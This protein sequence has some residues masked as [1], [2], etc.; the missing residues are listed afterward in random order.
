MNK[1]SDPL[2]IDFPKD[3]IECWERYPKYRWVYE[4]SRLLDSQ[5]IKWSPYEVGSLPDR[6]LNIE[7]KSIKPLIRQS[8]LIYIKKPSGNHMFTELYV[9]KGEIKFLRHIDPDTDKE[10]DS[11]IGEIELRINAFM[12]LYFQKFT[13]VMTI[14]TYGHEI[15]RVR[16]RPY[17]DISLETNQEIIKL[18]KRIYKKIDITIN[19]LA[20]RDIHETLAS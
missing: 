10:L 7:L 19:G 2:D 1:K 4:L 5:N 16:L 8:G 17:I 15:L 9:T 3:D 11:P 6:E 14:E 12:T 13:G 18:A 20:D